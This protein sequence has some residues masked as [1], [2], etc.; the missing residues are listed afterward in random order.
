MQ[1]QR[2]NPLPSAYRQSRGTAR[3]GTEDGTYLVPLGLVSAGVEEVLD[4]LGGATLLQLRVTGDARALGYS[5]VRT[6]AA[7]VVVAAA[8]AAAVVVVVVVVVVENKNRNKKITERT[9][10]RQIELSNERR[11]W[12]MLQ[13]GTVW[14]RRR[15]R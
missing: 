14:R 8:A 11:G 2:V 12:L 4:A 9:I 6:T 1:R 7:A 13:G 3:Q 15:L 5:K 10:G